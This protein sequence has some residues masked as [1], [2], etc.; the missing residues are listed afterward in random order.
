MTSAAVHHPSRRRFASWAEDHLSE[1]TMIALVLGLALLRERSNREHLIETARSLSKRDRSD[2]PKRG[3]GSDRCPRTGSMVKRLPG[4]S[5][6][7]DGGYAVATRDERLRFTSIA[8][9]R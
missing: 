5:S 8:W 9:C 1:P 6:N 7:W 3:C 4:I 2:Q